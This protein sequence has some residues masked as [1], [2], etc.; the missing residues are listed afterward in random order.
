MKKIRNTVSISLALTLLLIFA[1]VAAAASSYSLSSTTFSNYVYVNGGNS[2]KNLH[3][4]EFEL[5]SDSTIRVDVINASTN[6]VV[7][8]T[9]HDRLKNTSGGWFVV[10]YESWPYYLPDGDYKIKFVN[11]TKGSA[12][13]KGTGTVYY[14]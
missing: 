13:I 3:S 6:E 2:F 1:S 7:V 8:S 9:T 11:L 4:I 10:D 12:Y 14:N 5:D